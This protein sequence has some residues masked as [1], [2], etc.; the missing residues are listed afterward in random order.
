MIALSVKL[1][2]KAHYSRRRLLVAMGEERLC[3]YIET[4]IVIIYYLSVNGTPIIGTVTDYSGFRIDFHNSP[5]HR[6]G[7]ISNAD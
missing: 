3:Q 2:I 7:R 6:V 1:I 4:F 5:Y